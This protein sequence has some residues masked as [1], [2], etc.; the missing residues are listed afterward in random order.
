M[1][2]RDLKPYDVPGSLAEL[3]GP[4]SGLI[5]LPHGVRW[6]DDRLVV[7]VSNEG[8]RR[9]A[10]QA[11]LAEGF[12][13]EQRELLNRERLIEIWPVLHMDRRVRELWEGRFSELR[14]V[15]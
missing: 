11:L 7:D 9:M 3:R 13:D 8:W 4:Y 15:T 1:R 12:V 6:Q 5:D 2:F 10:Y 14:A